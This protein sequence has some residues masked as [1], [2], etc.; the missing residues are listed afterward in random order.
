MMA[1][2]G[3]ANEAGGGLA[4]CPQLEIAQNFAPPRLAGAR[5][6]GN[7]AESAAATDA[8]ALRIQPTDVDAGRRHRGVDQ[9]CV[10]HCR[11]TR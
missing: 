7:F 11:N 3:V 8:Q 6:F 1:K 10:D 9:R 2:P 5:P 4:R